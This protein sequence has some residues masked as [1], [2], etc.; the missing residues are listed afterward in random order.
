MQ[1]DGQLLD[2]N[3][4]TATGVAVHVESVSKRIKATYVSGLRARGGAFRD[5]YPSDR[6][7]YVW[8]RAAELCLTN[9]LSPEEHVYAL[10][11]VTRDPFPALLLGASAIARTR[12]YSSHLQTDPEL[13]VRSQLVHLGGLL[14][15]GYTLEDVLTNSEVNFSAAFRYFV[16]QRVGLLDVANAYQ[17]RALCELKLNPALARVLTTAISRDIHADRRAEKNSFCAS[18]PGCSYDPCGQRQ[19]G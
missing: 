2:G 11:E 15:T 1:K 6:Q 4:V 16:A 19:S 12:A 5:Y 3:A 14:S 18:G 8:D 13:D 17:Q 10:L 7:E 9:G